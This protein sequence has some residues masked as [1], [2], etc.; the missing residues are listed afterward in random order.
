MWFWCSVLAAIDILVLVIG[1]WWCCGIVV[2]VYL[3]VVV[4]VLLL[5]LMMMSIESK[6]LCVGEMVVVK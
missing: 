1:R 6:D 3:L 4:V 5:L 2:A